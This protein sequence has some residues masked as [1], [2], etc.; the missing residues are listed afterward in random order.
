MGYTSLRRLEQQ[1]LIQKNGEVYAFLTNEE[2][3]INR[4]ILKESTE[5]GEIIGAASAEI[6]E[7]ILT[8][9]KYRYSAR[10]NFSYNQIVDGRYFKGN[11]GNDIGVSIITPYGDGADEHSLR[12]LS[13]KENNVILRLPENTAF[14][15]EIQQSLRLGKYLQ[16][17]GAQL[18]VT[19]AAI[20]AAKENELMQ[21]KQRVRTFL[22][23]A[24]RD[25]DIYVGGDRLTIAAK[26]P[27]SRINEALGRLVALR[28]F[29]LTY[30]QTQPILK[31]IED[32][33]QNV[34]Q[35]VL[36]L[37]NIPRQN[38]QALDDVQETLQLGQ[39]RHVKTTLKTLLDKYAQAPYGFVESDV[40]WLVAALFRDGR[41]LLS[42]NGQNLTLMET[43]VQDLVRYLT[44]AE[45]REKLVAENREVVP[46][47]QIKAVGDVLRD[48]FQA[49]SIPQ[50]EDQL[51]S[52]FLRQ[53]GQKQKQVTAL[54]A[55]EYKLQPKLP[56]SAALEAARKLFAETG[57]VT[58]A[59]D[60][61]RF[62]LD[63]QHD[64]LDVADDLTPIFAFFAGEQKPI[65]EK[66]LRY[67]GLFE[68]SKTYITDEAMI[69][70]TS[71]IRDILR[72]PVPYGDIYKLPPLLETFKNLNHAMMLAE[73]EPVHEIIAADRFSVLDA[74]E[75]SPAKGK[76]FDRFVQL[77]DELAKRLTNAHAIAEIRNIGY[78]SGALKARCLQDIA[79]E[80]ARLAPPKPAPDPTEPPPSPK[81]RRSVSIRQM[82]AAATLTT[83]AEVNAYAEALRKRLLAELAQ[84]D[85]INITLFLADRS[86]GTP[87]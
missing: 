25:A 46:P 24:L 67:D 84:A 80:E 65:F 22:E 72:K 17:N 81:R 36:G 6:F 45:Y 49:P 10:Y 9:K 2:Q 14:W 48:L 43:P 73:A 32:L 56:G 20:K 37:A 66:A 77:Y 11:Q 40:Q 69:A 74:A 54:L 18:T 33:F 85:E 16:K 52:E 15:L 5:M 59:A 55:V 78:E 62:V 63:R 28:Y 82:L 12:M 31:D 47:Q 68:Q 27:A 21:V 79:K 58:R 1:T 35:L 7:N 38:A 23:E 83:E 39:A 61:F 19:F 71:Q 42:I 41:A 44:R 34:H 30:M 64:F 50:T 53:C 4:A 3:N 60:F 51:Q 75:A 13:G 57:Q 26:D 76:L 86:G 8:D 70:V 87:P 29:K